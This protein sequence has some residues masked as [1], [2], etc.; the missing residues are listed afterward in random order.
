M[1]RT[2]ASRSHTSSSLVTA[3]TGELALSSSSLANSDTSLTVCNALSNVPIPSPSSNPPL[4][5]NTTGTSSVDTQ[6][7]YL[8]VSR[9]SLAARIR[10]AKGGGPSPSRRIYLLSSLTLCPYARRLP[11]SL[12]LP[13]RLTPP[14]FKRTRRTPPRLLTLAGRSW[15]EA[16]S[17][18]LPS[19]MVSDEPSC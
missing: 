18:P 7:C 4:P 1:K 6:A 15:G 3:V 13:L 10:P 2:K 17:D 14:P 11:L 9:L 19:L 5:P 8:R 16:V 12:L